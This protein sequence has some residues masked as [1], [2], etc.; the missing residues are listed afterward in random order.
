MTLTTPAPE[1]QPPVSHPADTTWSLGRRFMTRVAGLPI[2]TVHGLRTPE[3]ARWADDVT[4]REEVLRERGARLSD[5][6]HDAVG[7]AADDGARRALVNIR[8]HLFNNKLPR[9]VAAARATATALGGTA[10]DELADWLRERE[11]LEGLRAAGDAVLDRE[12]DGV[13]SAL[14]SLADEPFLRQG[15]LL[16]SP[17]LDR[18]LDSY[19]RS[20]GNRLTK[21]QRKLERSLLEYVYRTACKTSP[22]STLTGL[23]LGEFVPSDEGQDGTDEGQDGSRGILTGRIDD[24]WTDHV[25]LNVAVLGRLAEL[26]TAN[27]GLRADLPVT[28]VSGWQLDTDRIR[29]VRRTVEAGDDEATVSFDAVKES[30]FFLRQGGSLER[31]FAMFERAASIRYQD[32]VRE[33]V[34]ASEG[35]AS[36]TDHDRFLTVLLRLGL[37]QVPGLS[38]DIHSRDALDSF[39]DSVRGIGTAW[40]ADLADR[41]DGPVQLLRAYPEA[42]LPRRRALLEE[43]RTALGEIQTSLGAPAAALPQ[44]LVYEDSRAATEVLTASAEQFAE[45]MGAELRSLSR[46]TPVFDITLAN[47][48]TLKG[49]FLARFGL[50]GRCDDVLKL[51]HDFQEDIYEQYL[52]VSGARTPFRVDGSYV[53]VDNWL[54]QPEITAIDN[55]RM[56]FV[57]G[58][59]ARFEELPENADELV[60]DEE[61][62]GVVAGELAD[63]RPRYQPQAH[64]VQLGRRP[65]GE[66]LGILN[67]SWGGVSFPFS[68]FTH[69]FD[70]LA[71]ADRLREELGAA[72]PEGAVHAEIT[73][74][75]A[76]T[77]LNL[78]GRLTDH[79]IV[80]PGETSSVPADA[81][82]PLD[83][84]WV[85]HD[86]AADRL[87]LRSRR[88]DREVIPVYLGYL[89][90]MA[91][92]EV[93]RILLLLSPATMASLDVWGGVPR[94]PA[95]DGV[96]VRPRVRHGNVVLS[97]RSWTVDTAQLPVRT[98]ETTDADWFRAWR[99]WRERHGI[100]E[101]VYATA[102]LTVR[103]ADGE[104]PAEWRGKEKPH[105]VDFAGFL[106]LTV[107]ER[108]VKD[109]E[110]VTLREAL[111]GESD[112]YIGSSR[113]RHMAELVV[114]TV[115]QPGPTRRRPEEA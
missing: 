115:S 50:G 96:T 88:L 72:R 62:V 49:F 79:E 100:P 105:Y 63:A 8:R 24:A 10:G 41:L 19:T 29:Y 13:R 89:L 11:E 87:V 18:Y 107:F 4:A 45:A 36:E 40:A 35:T 84:L 76:T 51:V 80:C 74:G 53:P 108:L 7:A 57:A 106:S 25:Q 23:A 3:A 20:T 64:F 21:Q 2:E 34:A 46:L 70:D 14:R 56:A 44:T 104:E 33:L 42:D 32:L 48:L 67:R 16:A 93:P 26:I 73:G 65:D 58:M 81:Q 68:R 95:R 82:I 113:G 6:L 54:Y 52:R 66:P 111:P 30:L 37:L 78:H 5:L 38:V 77:N 99:A 75:F 92:P 31:L 110:S 43:L 98:S 91:L 97:R 83:D 109:K 86:P 55:A 1:A 71:L 101:Q 102:G 12:L 69:C 22:F 85:E 27:P 61:F 90:P 28:L 15:L 103:G 17:S 114:E 94:R 112:L 47:R 39:R 59:R 60:V 9:D